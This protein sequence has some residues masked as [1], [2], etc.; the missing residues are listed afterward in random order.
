[1]K[2]VRKI[3]VLLFLISFLGPKIQTKVFAENVVQI[4]YFYDES[5]TN[6]A[7]MGVYL[8]EVQATFGTRVSINRYEITESP[9]NLALYNAVKAAFDIENDSLITTPFTVIGGVYLVGY[10]Q[11]VETNVERLVSRYLYIDHSDVVQK[12]IDDE[13]VTPD[14]F[15]TLEPDTIPI[16]FIGNVPIGEVS[17]FVSAVIFG[18]VDGFNPCAMWVLLF[19]ITMFLNAKDRKRMW[20]LGITFL[21]TTAIM[22]YLI[23]AAWLNVAISLVA[24]TWIRILIGLVA[25]GFGSYNLYKF[26]KGLK[27]DVGCEVTDANQKRRLIDKIKKI[28]IEKNFGL[29]L[30]GIILLAISVNFVELACSAGLP[31]LFTQI[32][33]FNELSAGVNYLYIGLYVFFFLLDDLLVFFIAMITLKVTGISTKYG[34]VSQVVGGIIMVIIAILLIFFPEIIR[35]NF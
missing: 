13:I 5:C 9:S 31:F 8:D 21:L 30:T 35:F 19:L 34:K 25:F 29:A 20:I 2:L 6:C 16:P 14:D 22:Y 12:V 11:L 4:H 33:A 1:M 24:V 26:F 28:V 18:T 27:K 3:L 17:L 23:M 7:K 10:N 15:D 32:L